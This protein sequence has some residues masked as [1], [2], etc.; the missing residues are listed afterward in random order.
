MGDANCSRHATNINTIV[1][2]KSVYV[3]HNKKRFILINV[4]H[5]FALFGQF[6]RKST[7]HFE[8]IHTDNLSLQI[9]NSMKGQ[10]PIIICSLSNVFSF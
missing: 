2:C 6:R 10:I 3:M 5:I 9:L 4:G 8:I 7:I 1:K